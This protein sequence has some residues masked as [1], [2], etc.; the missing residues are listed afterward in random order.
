MISTN[1]RKK[2]VDLPEYEAD[3][4]DLYTF[5]LSLQWV[6]RSHLWEAQNG[7]EAD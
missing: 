2:V 1:F 5:L 6:E 7:E 4:E 3:P